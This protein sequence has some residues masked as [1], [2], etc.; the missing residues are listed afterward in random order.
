MQDTTDTTKP[1]EAGIAILELAL[2]LPV[3][4]LVIVGAVTFGVILTVDHSLSAAASEGARAAVGASESEAVAVATA[5]ATD[6]LGALGSFGADA[7][8]DVAPPA[9]CPS[10][11]GARCITVRVT[12]PWDTKPIIP[13]LMGLVT[14]DELSAASTIQLTDWG[15]S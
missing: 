5:A 4:L 12:Y 2:T 7:V 13:D 8:V 1:D 15:T 3:L 10:P 11:A 9:D 6:Q 14:P